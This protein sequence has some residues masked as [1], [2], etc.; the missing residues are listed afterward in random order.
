MW[1]ELFL[2]TYLYDTHTHL[3]PFVVD[4]FDAIT[5]GMYT[6]AKV[7]E[8]FRERFRLIPVDGKR[9]DFDLGQAELG[10]SEF[11]G[12]EVTTALVL[13]VWMLHVRVEHCTFA[14]D[15]MRC[16]ELIEHFVVV[17]VLF[18]DRLVGGVA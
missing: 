13:L 8:H 15:V 4:M 11:T 18:V 14:R 12:S 16:Q 1:I 17:D 5:P 6:H 10:M 3:I 9:V 7:R 2:I